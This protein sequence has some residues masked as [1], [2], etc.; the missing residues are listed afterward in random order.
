MAL[1][2]STSTSTEKKKVLFI[3]GATGTGKTKLSINLG[4]QFPSEIINSD[5]IQV[6][7]GL[8]IV[9]NKVQESERCSIPH[10]I[11]GIIDDPEYDFTMDDFRKHVLEALDLITQ[12]EHL[13]IIVGGSNSYLKK[14]LEDPT[15]A[16]HSKYDCCF[17]WLDVSLPILFPYLDKRVDEMVAAGMV[18]EIRDFFVPGADNTK[19]IR[20][21]IGVPELDSYFEMEMKKG[22]DDVEKEKILKESIRKTKQNTF[23]LA[24]NQVSKIQ[25]MADTLGLMINKINSTEVFEAI[26]RGEDYQK[27]HQEIVIKPSMKIVKRFLEE[28]S[29]GFRNAKYS[30]GNGKHTT[31]G[32]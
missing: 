13:P 32:V 25:N 21:A 8:D 12:N 28:T 5:K 6:Y 9:T 20:R 27:L 31:N 15:N 7:N 19:G 11:L 16:F 26:L 3:L 1:T 4:T 14:L 22:I 2:T 30:N 23:I 29:H 18:D 10:H 17:I 24:E